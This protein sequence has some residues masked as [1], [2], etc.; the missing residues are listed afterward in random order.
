LPAG[1][2]I[3]GCE[4]PLRRVPFAV[5]CDQLI[6][7]F[8]MSESSIFK[9][10]PSEIDESDTRPILVIPYMWIGDFVRGH[11]A[12][13][14]LKQR[15]PNRPVDMLATT[16]CAPLADYMP[17]VRKAIVY[18]L[19]R[20]R[21]GLSRQLALAERM[22]SE[23]YGTAIVMPR[24]WKSALAPMF[25]GIP[26]RTGF[27]GELRFG[28]LN[29]RR[30]G[31][32][33]LERMIDRQVALT[34]PPNAPSSMNWPPPQLEVPPSQVDAWRKAND[35]GQTP[36][37]ALAPGA[38][39]PS[40]RWTE[41]AELARQISEAGYD[42]WIV[43]GPAEKPLAQA[44][45]ET[46]KTGIYDRTSADLR[47][48]IFALATATLVVS[49]DSGLMHV[50]AAIGRPTIGIFGPTSPFHWAPLNGLSATIKRTPNLVCQP[51][52]KPVCRVQHHR[53][54]RDITPE[55][56]MTA[57]RAILEEDKFQRA[58]H[59]QFPQQSA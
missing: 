11:T 9:L 10:E 5:W 35:I 36:V 46:R 54:M 49:N 3:F 50:A 29:D 19:L 12:V 38:V 51:C 4:L 18:D 8:K 48:G 16:L 2:S 22:R 6:A 40:K 20:S 23:S 39:G 25:A 24:T 27:L 30:S 43:G 59:P 44:I 57:I 1:F 42:V 58:G 34:L 15:W 56:V 13:R 21:I 33:T 53:C 52:H 37:V 26:E 45:S 17:G 14:V 28:L 32:K 31:E 47:N 7:A 41:Y 55:E